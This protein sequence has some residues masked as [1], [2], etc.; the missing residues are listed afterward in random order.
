MIPDD[1]R[2][3]VERTFGHDPEF[4]DKVI[5]S[6]K[7]DENI[8]FLGQKLDRKPWEMAALKKI[9]D[10]KETSIVPEAV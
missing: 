8:V 9:R 5:L 10:A 7:L 2:Q 3:L 4:C 6:L 1:L